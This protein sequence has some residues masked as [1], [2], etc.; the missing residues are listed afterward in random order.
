M[1]TR[2]S[3]SISQAL[4]T[5]TFVLQAT[6]PPPFCSSRSPRAVKNYPCQAGA[7]GVFPSEQTADHAAA[8]RAALLTDSVYGGQPEA[9]SQV[10]AFLVRNGSKKMGSRR[11][12][13]ADAGVPNLE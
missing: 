5:T 6:W 3:P 12:V 11:L 13:H 9:C 8:L 2:C 7:S 4:S 10:L 1:S